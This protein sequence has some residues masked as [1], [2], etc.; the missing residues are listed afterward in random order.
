MADV[1]TVMTN[2]TATTTSAS[3]TPQRRPV[4]MLA[5]GIVGGLCLGIAARLWMRL[6][7]DDPD[8][9]WNGTLFIVFGFAIFGF[10]QS[11]AAVA[12]RRAWR[13]W[14]LT[15]MRTIGTVGMLPLFVGA[16]GV[17]LPTVL[18]GGLAFARERWTRITRSLCLLVASAPVVFVGSDLVDKFGCSIHAA[19]GFV[20]MLAVY[21]TIIRAT[22][23]TFAQQ[24]DGW[25]LP[26]WATVVICVSLGL[27]FLFPLIGGG[28]S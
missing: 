28:I 27:L 26:R 22:R 8:F 6:I 18:G 24:F 9:T 1:C 12:R 7:A 15:V 5:T 16:G 19:A 3:L 21:G 17:M 4:A 11:I 14:T 20:G 10:A 13:R 23:S 25:R 2:L